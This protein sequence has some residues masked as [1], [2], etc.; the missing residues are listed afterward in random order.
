MINTIAKDSY[1]E[2]VSL[3]AGSIAYDRKVYRE[4]WSYIDKHI[5]D[6][7]N[8]EEIKDIFWDI[9]TATTKDN[10]L[11]TYLDVCKKHLPI[12]Q[13][14]LSHSPFNWML[15]TLSLPTNYIDRLL[16]QQINIFKTTNDTHLSIWRMLVMGTKEELEKDKE[17][18]NP[19]NTNIT[20]IAKTLII[21]ILS[22]L[23][24]QEEQKKSAKI[25]PKMVITMKRKKTV[26]K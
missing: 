16:A 15:Q 25:K 10:S 22:L 24:L 4:L 17:A 14:H 9:R 13:T 26:K 7:L 12:L 23:L 1:D 21:N 5:W 8:K 19:K 2:H 20:P 3:H 6:T 11:A 18:R